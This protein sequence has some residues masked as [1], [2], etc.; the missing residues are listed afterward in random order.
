MSELIVLV[1]GMATILVFLNQIRKLHK[2]EKQIL[3]HRADY[4]DSQLKAY[5]AACKLK[6][7]DAPV[8]IHILQDGTTYKTWKDSE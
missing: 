1:F 4:L 2:L 3:E 6:D 7:I 5:E 8:E